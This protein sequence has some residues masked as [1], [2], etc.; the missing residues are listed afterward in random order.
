MI[1]KLLFISFITFSYSYTAYARCLTPKKDKIILEQA[2]NYLMKLDSL[3]FKKKTNPL[4][5]IQR[6]EFN[7]LPSHNSDIDKFVHSK[8][9]AYN[10]KTGLSLQM[11]YNNQMGMA[12]IDYS[13]EEN[14]YP[15][16]NRVQA[17]L[18]WNIMESSLIGRKALYKTVELEGLLELYQLQKQAQ[19]IKR[20][21]LLLEYENKWDLIISFIYQQRVELLNEVLYLKKH[22]YDS[23]EI[24]YS[25]VTFI[26]SKILEVKSLMNTP[27]HTETSKLVP[28]IDLNKYISNFSLDTLGLF[29]TYITNNLNL[30]QYPAEQQLLE[31]NKQSLSYYKQIKVNIF[32]KAQYFGGISA[33][34]YDG[35]IDIGISATLPLSGEHKR[36]MAVINH[37]ISINKLEQSYAKDNIILQYNKQIKQLTSLNNQLTQSLLSLELVEHNILE[38]RALY[39]H[40]LA[41]FE[42]LIFEYNT[43]LII[44]TNIY[45]VIKNREV[46]IESLIN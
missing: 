30:K 28:F 9:R 29:D 2:G 17:S 31:L 43:Y 1:L 37:E 23:Q 32:A 45:F 39:K 10:S 20:E 19:S 46:L 16:R 34:Q 11:L 42:K 44:L 18:N 21:N 33:S 7:F 36:K 6:K 24:L 22:L 41:S 3:L 8:K 4:Q 5:I 15:Y 38:Y 12:I 14:I 25:N 40:N 13:D 35:K 27:E 26:E